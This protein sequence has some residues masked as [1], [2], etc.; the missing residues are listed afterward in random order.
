M[1]EVTIRTAVPEDTSTILRV[2]ER[3]WNAAYG[4]FLSQETI[5]TAMA[6]WYDPNTVRGH[7]TRDDVAYFVAE[8]DG[9]ILG[10]VSGGPSGEESTATLGAIYVDPDYWGNGIGTILLDKFEEFCR[11]QEYD[12]I[13]FQV[14]TQNDVGIAFYRKY[15]YDVVE[16]RDAELF[17]EAV[18]EYVFCGK[19][20]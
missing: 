4:D 7:I 3:G 16:E 18:R 12:T 13:Q 17:G 15:G 11:Q 20:E 6:E 2:A 9:N 8:Q 14:L 5:D 10:Y 1:A 19:I